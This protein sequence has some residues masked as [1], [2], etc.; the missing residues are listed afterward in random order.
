MR[1][2]IYEMYDTIKLKKGKRANMVNE[3]T[4]V[5]EWYI[6]T[7]STDTMGEE[8]RSDIT[9]YDIFNA[10]DKKKDFY[11][12]IGVYD[13]LI[14]ERIFRQLAKIMKV[15]YMYIYNQWLLTD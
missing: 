8:I 5:K 3:N 2:A 6:K 4:N 11:D 1:G 7:Y 10:L 12:F 15:D 14:R 9:F 13:S